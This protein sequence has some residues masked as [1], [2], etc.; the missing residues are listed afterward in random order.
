MIK[1]F[2]VPQNNKLILKEKC[3]EEKFRRQNVLFGP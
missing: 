2:N 1:K 3:T